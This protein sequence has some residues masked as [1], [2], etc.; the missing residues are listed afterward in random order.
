M[1]LTEKRMFELLQ[2]YENRK[3]PVT[4]AE[5]GVSA[6]IGKT[7]KIK[8]GKKLEFFLVEYILLGGTSRFGV[9]IYKKPK[10]SLRMPASKP[11]T[12]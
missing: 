1:V 8:G 6:V 12:Q 7:L 3:F 4:I 9:P 11:P 2:N 5:K 10:P